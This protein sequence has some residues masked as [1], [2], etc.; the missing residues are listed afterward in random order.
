MLN[1]RRFSCMSNESEILAARVNETQLQLLCR[2]LCHWEMQHDGVNQGCTT[3]F[4]DSARSTSG[5]E[6]AGCSGGLGAVPRV[7]SRGKALG[8]GFRGTKSP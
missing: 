6:V 1:I 8:Q 4:T 7:G 2:Q 3:Y 5:R